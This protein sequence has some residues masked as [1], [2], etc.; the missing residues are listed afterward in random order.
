MLKLCRSFST[1]LNGNIEM[2]SLQNGARVLTDST[3]G[4]FTALGAYITAGSRF[5]DPDKSG[6]SH[7]MDRM[8]WRSTSKYSGVEMM[9]K[10]SNL[11]G[12][13]MCLSQREL[14]IYQ[15]SV[16]NQ[17]VEEM[18]DCISQTILEPSFTDQEFEE[19]LETLRFEI[20]EMI[21][22][23]DVV[24]PELLHKVAY[25]NN[26]LGLPLYCSPERLH[27]ITKQELVDYHKKFYQPQNMVFSMIGV[28]HEKVVNLVNS[29]YGKLKGDSIN[30]VKSST[31]IYRGGEI[32]IPFQV[33]QFANLPHLFHMQIGFQTS[34][35]LNDELYTLAILQKLL[36]GG[37]SF[38]AGGP[39]KGMFSRLYTRVLNRYPFIE[40]CTSFNH[41]YVDSGLFGINI[42]ASPNAAHVM[43]QIIASELSSLLE[44]NAIT[45]NEF[46]RAR[47]QL[48][49]SLLYNV[50]SKLA[51]LEDFGRQIQCQ[52]KLVHIDEMIEHINKVEIKDIVRVVDKFCNS[53]PS[54]VM[55]GDRDSFGDINDVLD[56]FG[57]KKYN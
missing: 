8:A 48:V 28:N 56:H 41:S 32:Q 35:L 4:H 20:S 36:G 46:T 52:G 2:T 50:E 54:V 34:G 1:K 47:N 11:G 29:N 17:D 57:L 12:N 6:L 31:P 10:L 53:T 18:F 3:P 30:P 55:Q 33:P 44:P 27:S 15:A 26:T 24:L 40:N 13:Y 21:H 49:S 42:S 7:V 16:F 5:E 23:P 51:A 14:M 22:K 43:P 39:G 38:S 25:P 45:D 19:T 37:S 9:N